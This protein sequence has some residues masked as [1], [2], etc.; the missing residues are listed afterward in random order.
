MQEEFLHA[1]QDAELY[2][3]QEMKDSHKN[4]GFEVKV[5]Q[6][7]LRWGHEWFS[8]PERIGFNATEPFYTNCREWIINIVEGKVSP[9]ERFNEF[10]LQWGG[11]N[12]KYNPNFIPKLLLYYLS[13]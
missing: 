3:T 8:E 10:C 5:F 4:I 12:G 1:Y 9:G 7:V 11:D 2:G 13:R 6:D